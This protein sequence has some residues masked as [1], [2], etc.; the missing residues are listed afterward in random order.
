M[1]VG[2]DNLTIER[3]VL[4]E[5]LADG[6]QLGARL[7]PRLTEAL[8]K[9]LGLP[10]DQWRATIPRLSNFLALHSD[11]VEVHRPDG[12]GDITIELRGAPRVVADAKADSVQLRYLPS[13]WAAFLNPD[14]GRRRFFH[15]ITHEVVH[16]L[17]ASMEAPNPALA[18]R[19]ANDGSFVEI[20]FASA[21]IQRGW[22]AEFLE[23][24]SLIPNSLKE[25]A[26][27]FTRL[28]FTSS[29]NVG[30]AAALG[31]SADAWRRFR[32]NK[33]N[34]IITRWAAANQIDGA[35]L[36]H[37][38]VEKKKAAQEEP[39]LLREHAPVRVSSDI[40]SV[41]RGLTETMDDAELRS[42]LVPLSAFHRLIRFDA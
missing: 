27:H 16:F 10:P 4:I 19:V 41:L 1:L 24:S 11:L 28:P 18:A 23:S 7:K 12:E 29:V 35:H 8:G 36:Q 37:A 17:D 15:R 14:S 6:P 5:V 33:V 22:L 9:R 2:H 25:V 3:Q 20:A 34:E 31:Q 13:I 30:F 42:V 38:P 39:F 40:R 21:E 26:S 32:A